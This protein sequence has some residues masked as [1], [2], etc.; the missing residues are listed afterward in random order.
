MYQSKIIEIEEQD[1]SL[2]EYK[3]DKFPCLMLKGLEYPWEIEYLRD[4]KNREDIS[5]PLYIERN[6]E[7]FEIGTMEMTSEKLLEVF[8]ISKRSDGEHFY[9]LFICKSETDIK[10]IDFTDGNLIA[11]FIELE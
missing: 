6:D 9:E 10:K 3:I 8:T 5:L 1:N 7:Y 4:K 11:N 2:G